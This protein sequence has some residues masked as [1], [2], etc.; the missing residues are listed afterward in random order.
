MKK[1]AL[2]TGILLVFTGFLRAQTADELE[3]L[4]ASPRVSY[5]QAAR[6]VL[7]A[8]DAGTYR[9]PLEA[10][11]YALTREWLP[12]NVRA[13]DPVS[14]Q[15]ASFLIMQSFGLKGGLF[16]SIFKNAHY[17][18]RELVFQQIILDGADPEQLVSGELFLQIVNR[19]LEQQDRI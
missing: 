5:A 16:Y 8:A 10:F 6:F 2:L 18:Y 1:Y 7:E 3:T 14:L 4:L 17:S 13:D 15:G 11:D 9:N 12:P 19:V